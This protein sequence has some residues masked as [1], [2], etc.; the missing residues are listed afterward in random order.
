VYANASFGRKNYPVLYRNQSEPG[1]AWTFSDVTGGSGVEQLRST[2]QAA[3]GDFDR[4]G[5]L[6][7]VTAGKLFANVGRS[8]NWCEVLLIGD[9]IKTCRD[10]VGTQVRIN[11]P[12]GRIITRQVEIGTGEGNVNSPILHFGLGEV[13]ADAKLKMEIRWPDGSRTEREVHMN[14]MVTIEQGK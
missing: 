11:L 3:W 2:Y 6:D 7:L 5:T 9:G 10:A 12:G 14:A 1:Q 8:G 4:N 13:A